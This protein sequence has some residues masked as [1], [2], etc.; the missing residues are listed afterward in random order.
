MLRVGLTGG[1]GSGKS[2][3]SRI[4]G[5]LGI[6]V[7]AADDAARRIQ[8]SDPAV[9]QGIIGLF[10]EKAYPA[11]GLDRAYISSI[12]FR[13]PSKLEALNAIVHPA[14]IRDAADWL[15]RQTAPYAIKEAALIFESG[16]QRDLD[17]VIGVTA[18]PDLRISRTMERD[19]ISEEEVRRRMDRQISD[20]IKMRL[21]DFVIHNDEKRLLIP[22]VLAIHEHL[23]ARS[24]GMPAPESS[25]P[26]SG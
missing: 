14:T 1:I 2:L 11:S 23:L 18:P 15:S 21:C 8:H 4:F 6:P 13:D 3:V 12:V 5:S 24:A 16:S 25:P 10:G 19:G 17:L 9:K 22:Q 20:V 7:Y 26:A